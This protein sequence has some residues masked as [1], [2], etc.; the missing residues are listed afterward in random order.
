MRRIYLHIV[1]ISL[2]YN[3]PFT[4][5]SQ[6]STYWNR[7]FHF[8]TTVFLDRKDLAFNNY[9]G[10]YQPGY[11]ASY[12]LKKINKSGSGFIL[13]AGINTFGWKSAES[14]YQ[15]YLGEFFLPMNRAVDYS[16]FKFTFTHIAFGYYYRKEFPK[17]YLETDISPG[18]QL[19][20][21]SRY[22]DIRNYI[23]GASV[24]RRDD[25]ILDLNIIPSV[26]LNTRITYRIAKRH[27]LFF[28][29]KYI[30]FLNIKPVNYYSFL[31]FNIGLSKDFMISKRK[32][33]NGKK[34]RDNYIYAE[35]M[36]LAGFYSMNYERNV[37]HIENFRLNLRAGFGY[38]EH[39]NFLAGINLVLGHRYDRFELGLTYNYRV[40]EEIT[41]PIQ[42]VSPSISYRSETPKNWLYKLTLGPAVKF[43]DDVTSYHVIFGFSLGK[44][45]GSK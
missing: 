15:E 2:F 32:L 43:Q 18:M 40:D 22:R 45:F 33:R 4:L 8:G 41:V 17:F 13:N 27:L 5:F 37:S 34:Y 30:G 16:I 10:H 36:G 19:M 6:D 9:D 11:S 14:D 12:A 3:L 1:F 23:S 21:F 44:R 38:Y 7:E 25:R 31:A 26:E 42:F 28:N 35:G 24:M 20:N 29:L 39:Y